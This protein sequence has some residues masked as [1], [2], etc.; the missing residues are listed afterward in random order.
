MADPLP[1]AETVEDAMRH[2]SEQLRALKKAK[3]QNAAE[4]RIHSAE[5][6]RL[7]QELI[8]ATH[9]ATDAAAAKRHNGSNGAKPPV[10]VVA[11]DLSDELLDAIAQ[12]SAPYIRETAAKI[13]TKIVAEALAEPIARNA[14]SEQ[15]I[16]ELEAHIIKLEQL[17][18]PKYRGVW[19]AQTGYFVGDFCT[20]DG[21]LWHCERASTGVRPGSMADAW[22][23]AVKRG[24]DGKG[25]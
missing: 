25:R 15:R 19:D 4:A 11:T 1:A 24:R 7:Q 12:G 6:V 3:P 10:E 22:T 9:R 13:A 8:A 20:D 14:V 17:P 21:S 2:A 5:L 16:A 18:S 23:L